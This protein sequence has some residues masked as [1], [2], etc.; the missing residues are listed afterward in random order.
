MFAKIKPYV[1]TIVVTLIV[2]AIVKLAKEKVPL[3]NKVL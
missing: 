3:V 1:G 2:L